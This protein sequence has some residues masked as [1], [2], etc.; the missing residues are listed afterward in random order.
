[1]EDSVGSAPAQ[2]AE[3]LAD[4]AAAPTLP[5]EPAAAGGDTG[6]YPSAAEQEEDEWGDNPFA[7]TPAPVLPSEPE[8]AAQ[9]TAVEGTALKVSTPAGAA[10]TTAAATA[11]LLVLAL[12]RELL[13]SGSS[14][15]VQQ[16]SLAALRAHLQAQQQQQ[17]AE[18]QRSWAL[19]C[20]AAAL[21]GAAARVHELM[22]GSAALS[23]AD[24]QVV[25]EALKAG[26]LA[27]N[28]AGEA[29][30][31]RRPRCSACLCR[32]WWRWRPPCAQHPPR[33]CPTW[34]SSC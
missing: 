9:A 4:N 18:A 17:A 21:P 6:Q 30:P 13:G 32:P 1:M 16:H 34:L 25:A 20:A 11:R 2:Q 28:L 7:S 12:L 5:A 29:P 14:A 27:V 3:A 15:I 26:L 24:I 19:A 23:D 10:D 8:P 31:A 22:V 33:C